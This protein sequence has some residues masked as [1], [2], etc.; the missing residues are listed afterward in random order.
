MGVGSRPALARTLL[1]RGWSAHTPVAILFGASTPSSSRW[2]GTL[3]ALGTASVPAEAAG[4]PGT[5]VVGEVVGLAHALATP[6]A[7]RRSTHGCG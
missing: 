6:E 3:D 7:G 2:M 1:A 5:I 4:A